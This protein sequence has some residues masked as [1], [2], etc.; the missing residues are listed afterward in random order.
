VFEYLCQR[1]RPSIGSVRMMLDREMPELVSRIKGDSPE[2]DLARLCQEID[3]CS[4]WLGKAVRAGCIAF[5]DSYKEG[6][7][8]VPEELWSLFRV[9]GVASI[10]VVLRLV[11]RELE[12]EDLAQRLGMTDEPRKK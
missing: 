1:V 10:L 7:P 12:A 4:V 2:D 6:Y 11:E 8:Y 5:V 3:R 9:W